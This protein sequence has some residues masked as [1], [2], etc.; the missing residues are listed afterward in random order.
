[1]IPIA[2]TIAIF[3]ESIRNNSTISFGYWYTDRKVVKHGLEFQV[4][5]GIVQN[6]NSPKSLISTHETPDRINEPIKQNNIAIFDNLDVRK[7]FVGIDGQTYPKNAIIENYSENDFLNQCKDLKLFYKKNVGKEM[8]NLFIS[9]PNMK[10][11]FLFQYL[12]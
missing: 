5:M 7:N 10:N 3:K 1:M 4:V 9:F 12:I 11:F 6:I 2:E 8:L